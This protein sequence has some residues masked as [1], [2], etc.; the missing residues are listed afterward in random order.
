MEPNKWLGD[1]GGMRASIVALMWVAACGDPAAPAD[2]PAQ[3][4]A[5][6]APRCGTGGCSEGDC[7]TCDLRTELCFGERWIG[8]AGDS[9]VA[10]PA[11]STFAV[12]IGGTTFTADSAAAVVD[13]DY[14]EVEALFGS[15]AIALLL[16]AAPG[17][18]T[19]AST[20]FAGAITYYSDPLTMYSNRA[21]SGSRPDCAVSVTSV[22]V[23]GQPIT[24]A[25]SATVTS[26]ATNVELANGTFSVGRV[27]F[28]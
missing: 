4:E 1:N 24:G 19:C 28:P 8:S 10:D 22:G 23:V 9:C 14:V 11:P 20:A 7:L 12:T 3:G 18:D 15:R 25:F 21:A 6:P 16:D 17:D 2:A 13:G 26:G 27:A 5:L